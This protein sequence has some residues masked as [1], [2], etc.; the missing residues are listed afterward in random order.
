MFKTNK[1]SL[2]K[3]SFIFNEADIAQFARLFE[4]IE[5]ERLSTL[6]PE[7]QQR[8]RKGLC[9]IG[10]LKLNGKIYVFHVED[11]YAHTQ[12]R[13]TSSGVELY[14][15][16]G[17]KLEKYLVPF[18]RVRVFSLEK[19][20]ESLNRDNIRTVYTGPF[21]K[22]DSFLGLNQTEDDMHPIERTELKGYEVEELEQNNIKIVY[23]DSLI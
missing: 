14:L 15:R 22:G 1:E 23:L 19:A 21:R 18:S 8:L 17:D 2:D 9:D 16:Q 12:N 20:I 6:S 7:E 3:L 5:R 11:A 13:N 10:R 4:L